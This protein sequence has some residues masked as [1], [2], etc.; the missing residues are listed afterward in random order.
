MDQQQFVGLLES[1]MLPDTERVKAATASLNKDYYT[2]PESL[3]ALLQ[4]LTSH[5]S[6]QLRQLAAVESRK[7][8]NKHWASLPADQKPQMRNA[9]L[10]ATMREEGTLVRH[11]SA[12]VIAAIAK[13]DLE[14]GQWADLPATLQQAA[15]SGEARHREVSVF[16]I[17][18]LIETMGE[19]FSENLNELFVLFGQT[20]QDPDSIEVRVNTMLA[21]SR[22]AMLLD[23]DEDAQALNAFHAILPN[24]VQVL[25]ATIDAGDEDRAMQAFEVFQTLLG[26]ES[27]LLNKHFGDLIN[28]MNGLGANKNLD[29]DIRS[30]AIAFLM[31]CVRYRKLKIQGLRLGEK[32]TLSSLEIVTELGDLSSDDEEVTP[33]RSA[34]GLLDILA[35]SLPPSQVIVP[36]LQAMG[37]Y[38]NSPDP[39][40]RRAGILSLG[41]TVEGAP[42]FIAT[43]LG[44]IL[45]LVLHL[46]EDQDVKVRAAA[47]NGVARLADDLAEE[48]GKEHAK[49]IPALVKNL[50][51][52]TEQQ[53]E[54]AQRALEVL[55]GSCNAIDSLIEGLEEEEAAKYLDELVPRF[56]RLFNHSDFKTQIASA[57]AVGS[58]A[59]AAGE[60]FQRYFQDTMQALSPF[61][62]LKNSQD[63]LDL[64][65][66]V[67]DSMGKIAGAVGAELFRPFLPKLMMA[68]EEALHLDHPRLRETSYI[69]WSTMAKVYEEGFASYLDGV[70]KGLY[71]CLEQDE[72]DLEVGLGQEAKDLIGQEV[73]VGGKKVR[74][75]DADDDDDN[76]V[77]EDDEDDDD[78]DD[79][80]AV[81]AVA[82]E[83]EIAVEVV[84]DVIISTR[85]NYLP[86]LPKTIE[87]VLKL[88]NH[89]YEGV[90]KSAIGTLWR[91][92]TC[93]WGMA[94]GSGMSK[95]VPGIPLQ[96]QPTEDLI[97]LGQLAMTA[98]LEVLEDE[99]DRGTVTDV[100][101]DLGTAL[102]FTGPAILVN[103]NGTVI[104]QLTTQLVS[105]LTKHHPCQQDL[106]EEADED[107]LEETSEYD[108]LVIEVALDAVTCLSAALGDSFS[109]LFKIFEK[110]V[111]KYASSQES[112]ERSAAVGSV[113][114]C[115][116]N[117]AGG[118]TPFTANL[119]KVM[120]HRLSDEDPET[121]SNAAYAVGLLCSASNDEQEILKNFGTI[122][123]KLEPMLH[124][125]QQ[126]RMLDN[127][128]GCISRMIMRY[129]NNVPI[130]QVLPR[131]I[132]LLPLR[133]D[134]E[135]N[136]PIFR[137]LV[138]LYQAQNAT[139]QQLTAQLMPI[140]E[141]VLSPPEEQLDEETRSQL[142]QLVQYLQKQ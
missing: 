63:E 105:I 55:R 36:L 81:T 79:F 101:R 44:D 141:K 17:F 83:K 92:Y 22:V 126:A 61:V 130:D 104:P 132:D 114:D 113:A 12:R 74:V 9:L 136:Q 69:L 89:S 71:E 10:E 11:S 46:L 38:V 23:P 1:L 45:P 85:N 26:C 5:Q 68:S 98:T 134:F 6:P 53:G 50:D 54:N 33:A 3:V 94:E 87:I 16:M 115:I 35:Q 140:F 128:A 43:Q 52:A 65:G 121:R 118:V 78:W 135:E 142:V 111:M 70:V 133:E 107:I 25:Q 34:L 19:M 138:K 2:S 75:A 13:L 97:K 15:V 117:M 91:A 77:G 7:L 57:G 60:A 112:T 82:M 39:D 72:A 28:F 124:D 8:V 73:T 76:V 80:G 102:K 84:G 24:M 14:E 20:I 30:Q 29:D 51:L 62:E 18:T 90:R 56:A 48:L 100:L 119:M 110:P 67:C 41:M 137:M 109:E 93:L 131:L 31:Q 88:V 66:V 120:L 47:L 127:A 64:R 40:R 95:W 125:Q 27:A 32:L 49:I 96:V 103:Q 58:L 37:P 4:I 59:A 106:G 129:P 108:W 21:L 139:V 116:G 123:G 86:H 42:D 122:F 99:M